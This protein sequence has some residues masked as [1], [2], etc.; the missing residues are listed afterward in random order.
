MDYRRTLLWRVS[1]TV[2]QTA[3]LGL[4]RWADKV[5]TGAG[6]CF[7]PKG[8]EQPG[9]DAWLFDDQEK[10]EKVL[11]ELT[12]NSDINRYRLNILL[13]A[14][15]TSLVGST[16]HLDSIQMPPNIISEWFPQ[17]KSPY[18]GPNVS[19]KRMLEII[20]DP[21]CIVA[22]WQFS[23]NSFGEYWFL[24]IFH[25]A[26]VGLS[27][28]LRYGPWH[29]SWY[30]LGENWNSG[31]YEANWK[32]V[33]NNSWWEERK[34]YPSLDKAPIIKVLEEAAQYKPAPRKQTESQQL[35]SLLV[36]LTDEDGAI[37]EM[38]DLGLW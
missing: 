7:C 30:G 23:E 2:P 33:N 13:P 24:D 1:M 20:K 21:N 26:Q 35:Y 4:R 27:K 18:S 16:A 17:H 38:E 36:E 32:Y 12:D 29:M 31:L 6:G 37:T 5:L 9:T 28:D 25:K 22:A 11:S 34:G 14:P 15:I 3:N 10:A 19:N 8:Y